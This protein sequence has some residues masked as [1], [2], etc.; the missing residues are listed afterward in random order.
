MAR[1]GRGTFGLTSRGRRGSYNNFRGGFR[2]RGSA[3]G[4]GGRGGGPSKADDK[5]VE[6]GDDGT[7]AEER[8]ERAKLE[9]EVD[10]KM[11][12]QKFTE[13]PK[14]EAWL[15]NMHPVSFLLLSSHEAFVLS[16]AS[17]RHS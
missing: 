2:R 17:C 13:G 1:G 5:E 12:F 8:F 14:R 9:D 11:G 4:R 16:R 15:V 6:R 7:Q 3:R 10:E